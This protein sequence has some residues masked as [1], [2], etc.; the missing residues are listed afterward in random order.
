MTDFRLHSSSANPQDFLDF[1][2]ISLGFLRAMFHHVQ[3]WKQYSNDLFS[4][5]YFLICFTFADLFATKQYNFCIDSTT[6]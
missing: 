5:G 3:L 1:V 4:N 2:R 6:K